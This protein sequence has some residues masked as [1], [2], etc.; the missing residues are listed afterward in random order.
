[1]IT[2]ALPAERIPSDTAVDS[3]LQVK[4][5][6]DEELDAEVLGDD[7]DVDNLVSEKTTT[8]SIAEGEL[9]H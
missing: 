2:F 1:M 7:V 6:D 4:S 9:L 3:D 5:K 8:L